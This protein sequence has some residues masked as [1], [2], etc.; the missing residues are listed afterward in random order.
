MDMEPTCAAAGAHGH[1]LMHGINRQVQ[2]LVAEYRLD[3]LAAPL[4][5]R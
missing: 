1:L 4:V 3:G 2:R 5:T